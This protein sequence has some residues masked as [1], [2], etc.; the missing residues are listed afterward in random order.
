MIQQRLDVTTR[1]QGQL[2]AEVGIL[3]EQYSHLQAREEEARNRLQELDGL[4]LL[5]REK[6]SAAERSIREARTESER[7]SEENSKLSRDLLKVGSRS[8]N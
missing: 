3:R 8:G 2:Q 7:I 6:S 4:L 5:E 1:E